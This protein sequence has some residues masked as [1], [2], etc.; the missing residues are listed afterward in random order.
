MT[1][2][3]V[4][5]SDSDAPSF[6]PPGTFAG[7]F[8]R[9]RAEAGRTQRQQQPEKGGKDRFL[10]AKCRLQAAAL[11]SHIWPIYPGILTAAERCL[12]RRR[13]Q[14]AAEMRPGPIKCQLLLVMRGIFLGTVAP[15]AGTP[16]YY[17]SRALGPGVPPSDLPVVKETA[18]RPAKPAPVL[19]MAA[20]GLYEIPPSRM[21]SISR[22]TT[23]W[24]GVRRIISC[25]GTGVGGV[26][27]RKGWGLCVG[28]F[29]VDMSE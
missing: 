26:G 29:K 15:S 7:H 10:W 21:R 22:L 14:I 25:W 24:S 2:P 27:A 5:R 19:I 3:C 20:M 16:T 11:H 13:R 8:L 18:R 9:M 1:S 12:G 4:F 28:D 23:A 17:V 6:L